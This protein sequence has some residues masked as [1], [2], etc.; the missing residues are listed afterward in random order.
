MISKQFGEA[1]KSFHRQTL[2]PKVKEP[3]SK[4]S[5]RIN[6]EQISNQVKTR[7]FGHKSED[8]IA[9]QRKISEAQTEGH[10]SEE[11]DSMQP[12]IQMFIEKFGFVEMNEV[13]QIL[14]QTLPVADKQGSH[15]D[16]ATNT[17]SILASLD[18]KPKRMFVEDVKDLPLLEQQIINSVN[19]QLDG[20]QLKGT[21]CSFAISPKTHEVFMFGTET[22]ELIECLQGE[23]PSI[24]K[25]TLDA[26]VTSIAVSPNDEFFAAGS[27]N[28]ELLI[29]KTKG[30]LAKK[31][32]KSLNQ[33][34]IQ[35]LVFLENTTLLVATYNC[36][37]HFSISS[38]AAVLLELNHI[39]VY[40]HATD[41]V[42]QVTSV[43]HE[44]IWKGL[45]CLHDKVVAFGIAKEDK[46][47]YRAYKIGANIEHAEFVDAPENNKWPPT[48]DW[49]VP[50]ETSPKPLRF[51][52]IWRNYLRIYTMETQKWTMVDQGITKNK[53]AWLTVLDNRLV[54]LANVNL[55]FEFLSVE[56]LENTTF[57]D[58][59]NHATAKID[60][61]LL[62]DQRDANYM[63]KYK[64]R[65][66]EEDLVISMKLPFFSFFKNRI[67]DTSKGIY[68]ITDKGLLRYSFCGLDKLVD[69]YKIRG[70]IPEALELAK[71]ALN[72]VINS[73]SHERSAI[74]LEAPPIVK[75]YVE[76]QIP[77]A[78]D[79]AS[80][81]EILAK[82]IE[83]LSSANNVDFIFTD[84]QPKFNKRLFWELV[85][86]FV[87]RKELTKIPY[88]HLNDG[89]PYLQN[90]EVAEICKDFFVGFQQ[91]EADER[92]INKVL[93]IM[94]KKNIWPFLYKFCVHFPSQAIPVFL[95]SLASEII[96]MDPEVRTEILQEAIWQKG[97]EPNLNTYFE[98][99][100]RRLFFR[101]FWFFNLVLSPNSLE[102]SLSHFGNPAFLSS[103]IDEVHTKTLE[104][105]LDASNSKLILE[106][107]RQMYFEILYACLSNEALLKSPKVIQLVKRLKRIYLKKKL[108]SIDPTNPKYIAVFRSDQSLDTSFYPFCLVQVI[109][110]ILEFIL[111]IKYHQELGF[112]AVKLLNNSQLHDRYENI[113]WVYC[114]LLMSLS[115]VFE[116]SKF[117]I[118]YQP[119]TQDAFE[120][121]IIGSLSHLSNYMDK[122]TEEKKEKKRVMTE[123]AYA[124]KL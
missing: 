96:V 8:E 49:I 118:R 46:K 110:L 66:E 87:R 122:D 79:T 56:R 73:N 85:A 77:K 71:A 116:L 104:W 93:T 7:F 45:I 92:E 54:C 63:S 90:E 82:A 64:D 21:V 9:R 22:G 84:I 39:D 107:H 14:S 52:L 65:L 1:L 31:Y 32:L 57:I 88:H 26:K 72:G 117:W 119:V 80:Q 44:G 94:K 51:V 23:K 78:Q 48:V 36:V 12:T 42:M 112:L 97:R 95:T 59:G 5:T 34:R 108:E 27:A 81:N 13:D 120:D 124:S 105:I 37:Y 4:P 68:M 29:K 67:K 111:D 91:S 17:D 102:Q 121:L 33:Q 11:N 35:Q 99:E 109:I 47:T 55:E 75:S 28:S 16:D 58:D 114:S 30:K 83:T 15:A 2:Q 113:E 106:T 41:I 101:L 115:E 103:N 6:A 98:D 76:K 61:G 25:H 18:T 40:K 62:K 38:M 53:I 24:N 123:A 50:E 20:A 100:N 43:F 10:E 3:K 74:M 70:Q 19:I 89:L 60:Q 86:G 69:A